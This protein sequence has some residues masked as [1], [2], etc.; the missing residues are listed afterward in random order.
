[1]W[2][3]RRRSI[4][5]R[6]HRSFL[7]QAAAQASEFMTRQTK[8]ATPT[9]PVDGNQW[10]IIRD[11]LPYLWPDGRPDLKARVIVAMLALLVS[12]LVTV[13]TPY[14]FKYATDALLPQGTAVVVVGV[15]LT[16]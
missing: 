3:H 1:M 4:P 12:K 2:W 9:L 14:A 16:M 6:Q 13:W 5:A 8:P 10:V 15:A 11:L 7:L